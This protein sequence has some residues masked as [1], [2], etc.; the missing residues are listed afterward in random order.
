MP[1]EASSHPRDR[2]SF[3]WL[4]VAVA[5]MLFAARRWTVPLAAWLAPVFLLRFIRTQRVG[6]GLLF[7]WLA[8]TVVSVIASRGTILYPGFLPYVLVAFVSLLVTLAFLADRLVAPRLGGFLATLVFPAAFTTIE[9]LSAR[10]P[11]GT[12]NSIAYSQ[13]GDLPLMQLVS[14]TG[15]WGIV[16]LM[17]WFAAV[18]NW[19]WEKEFAWTKIRGGGL[20]FVTVLAVVLLAGGAR[21]AVFPPR[22]GQVSVA[23]VSASQ[24]AVAALHKQ[25]PPQTLDALLAGSDLFGP[26]RCP[27]R[28]RGHR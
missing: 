23:G 22:S 5:L 9:Y 18:A 10:G 7:A 6:W 26:G 20:T 27:Q 12:Y 28:L 17:T 1:S 25:L 19:A 21:L 15:I 3:L 4:A 16:F 2:L 13:Y 14:V 11:F 24:S 8:R